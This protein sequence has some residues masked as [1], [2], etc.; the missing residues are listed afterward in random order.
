MFRLPP[1]NSRHPLLRFKYHTW[2]RKHRQ[3]VTPRLPLHTCGGVEEKDGTTWCF[4]M[5]KLLSPDPEV[6]AISVGEQAL[7]KARLVDL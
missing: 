7:N 4:H 6:T 2:P 3:A 5:E 1:P